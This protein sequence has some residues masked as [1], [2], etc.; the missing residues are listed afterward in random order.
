MRVGDLACLLT[1]SVRSRAYIQKLLRADLVP[2][3]IL[4]FNLHQ[5]A[6]PPSKSD[7]PLFS[8]IETQIMAAFRSRKYFLYEKSP[9]ALFPVLDH[10]R[11]KNY[12]TFDPDEEVA[13]TLRNYNISFQSIEVENI[14]DLV[15]VET[16]KEWSSKYIIFSGGGILGKEILS[17]GKY[18]IHVH[19]GWVPD[20]KGSHCI[21]WSILT[22]EACAVS[23]IFMAEQIDTGP[24]LGR[25]EFPLPALE[26]KNISPL[27]SAHIRSAFLV[28]LI[29]RFA[30]DKT[31]KPIEQNPL[32]GTTYFKMHPVLNNIA[33]KLCESIIC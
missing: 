4:Y 7:K 14:N 16:I 33:L 10:E 26:G 6:K 8:N 29:E 13:Q 11:K 5:K 24:V 1:D 25:K 12:R 19:P 17:L 20:V 31:F 9:Q 2:E 3:N 32:K 21:E 15:V 27:F 23:A 28:E 18:F 22:R 30:K